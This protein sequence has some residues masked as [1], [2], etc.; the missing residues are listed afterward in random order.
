MYYTEQYCKFKQ[1]AFG[2]H[3]AGT[4]PGPKRTC[5]AA[6]ESHTEDLT[7]HRRARGLGEER[8]EQE[9]DE[10]DEGQ[11][12]VP[13]QASCGNRREKRKRQPQLIG[14]NNTFDMST[15]KGHS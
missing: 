7:L 13:E 12:I 10:V 14:V 6:K 8:N 11:G 9:V 15:V 4:T 1:E 5:E 3:W 2:T